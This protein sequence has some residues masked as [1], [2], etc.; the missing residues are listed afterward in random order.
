MSLGR[1]SYLKTWRT[2]FK[3]PSSYETLAEMMRS[4][5]RQLHT[6]TGRSQF[7]SVTAT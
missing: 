1:D 3:W 2:S 6:N 4:L 7:L 5:G